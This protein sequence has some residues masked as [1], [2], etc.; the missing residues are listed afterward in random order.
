VINHPVGAGRLLGKQPIKG[1]RTGHRPHQLHKS[2]SN[3]EGNFNVDQA[4]RGK[5]EHKGI[6]LG[7]AGGGKSV[8]TRGTKKGPSKTGTHRHQNQVPKEVGATGK[9][10][11]VR[12]VPFIRGQE[13]EIR[14]NFLSQSRSLD[15]GERSYSPPLP[16]SGGRLAREGRTT[17]NLNRGFSEKKKL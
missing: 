4:N 1:Q 13:G 5:R 6:G 7:E 3:N 15:S 11:L 8:P 10:C 12:E 14:G 9:R 17:R 2:V 16:L